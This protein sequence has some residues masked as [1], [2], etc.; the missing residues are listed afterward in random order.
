MMHMKIRY[1]FIVLLVG[2]VTIL[3]SSCSGDFRE[4]AKGSHGE[5]IVV[6]DSSKWD[7]PVAESLSRTFG[8][9]IMTLPQ[10]EERF[11]LNFVD[12]ATQTKLDQLKK[13]K[14]VIFAAP[15][16]EQTNVGDFIRDILSEELKQQVRNGESFGFELRNKWYRDQWTLFLT[17]NNQDSLAARIRSNSD[18]FVNN[19][20]DLEIQR[21]QENIYDRGEQTAIA[22]SLWDKYG[23]KIRIQHDYQHHVDT[24]NFVTLR[25]FLPENDRWIWAWWR[26]GVTDLDFIDSTWIN[27]MRDSLMEQHVRGTRDSSYVT[28]E[29][30]RP[31]KT[32]VIELNGY[33]AWQ[34]RGTWRMTGDFMGG[35]FVHYTIYDDETNRLF[36]IEFA[37]FAPKHDKRR[38][39]RQF[40]AMA[41]TFE[42]DSTW[43][44]TRPEAAG[45]EKMIEN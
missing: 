26:D 7:S 17:A 21:W 36:M 29:Y 2:S 8:E 31:V 41:R 3:F 34:T 11:D 24:T 15:L 14:N 45:S 27:N 37:Q 4:K 39:V 44:T 9:Y 20:E 33:Y 13:M 6:M 40:M 5:V 18:R 32:R 43:T 25:R 35:P 30:R 42:S 12:F 22:D 16:D 28:T 1:L 10:P 38:F 23:W 19:L